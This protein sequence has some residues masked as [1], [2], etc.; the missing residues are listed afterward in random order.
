[1]KIRMTTPLLVTISLLAAAFSTGSPVFL[2]ASLLLIGLMGSS[3]L[4]VWLAARSLTI[5][6]GLEDHTVNRGEDVT[7]DITVRHRGFIPIAP[8]A[9]EMTAT[10]DLP[11]QTLHVDASP[12]H[13]ARVTLPFHASHVGVSAPGVKAVT[14]S[15]L[16]GFVSVR[17]TPQL[18]G[19]E[20]LVL[21]LPFEVEGLYYAAGDSD[22]ETMAR[23]TED[24]TSPAD[25]RT[26]QQ[27]DAMKKIHWKLSMRKQ[28]LL[29]RRFEEP[30]LPDALV[31]MDCS[32]PP[33]QSSP[34][35]EADLR[36]AL[37]ETTASVMQQAMATDH[38]AR[39]PLYGE[40]PMELEKAMGLP[41]I[42]E[43]LARVDFTASDRFERVL[44]LEM[45]RMRKVGCTVIIAARLNSRMV[46]VMMGMRRMGPY[47][48]LYLVTHTPE[49]D[50]FMAMISKLQFA[51]VE[52][53]YVKPVAL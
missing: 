34:E 12:G 11:E 51:G 17:K 33:G 41:M 53:C 15:D 45:R 24:I 13:D 35:A 44:L 48:R 23:A 36:D 2:A 42:L 38:A 31:L 7:L 28:E 39:I 22:A 6:G 21:P 4:G 43:S 5:S 52:V 18:R 20:L 29:V 25:V 30:V 1:M 19:G 49:D 40:H 27:G 9:L 8:L 50:Q 47:V 32:A 37:L 46:D 3:V 16:F 10:P 14:V 26:Y